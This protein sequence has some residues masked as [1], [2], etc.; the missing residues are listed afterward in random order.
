[1]IVDEITTR[2]ALLHHGQED[3]AAQSPGG[4]EPANS[5]DTDKRVVIVDS[6]PLVRAGQRAFIEQIPGFKVVAEAS[7]GV[8]AIMAVKSHAADLAILELVESGFSMCVTIQRLVTAVPGLYVIVSYDNPAVNGVAS[9]IKA[10]V[11]GF[12]SKAA[13]LQELT[14][15]VQAVSGGAVYLPGPVS[16]NVFDLHRQ[17]DDGSAP[18]GLTKREM[19]ILGFL[20]TGLSNKEIANIANVSVR[21]VETH[22]LSIR[23]K[24]QSSTLS[25]LVRVARIVQSSSPDAWNTATIPEITDEQD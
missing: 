9:L 17:Q 4:G 3:H 20:S 21:T 1:M 13:E 18:Y 14:I 19:E 24:T 6:L 23:R 11:G 16:K 25:D 15:A 2:H 22:R 7:D 12:V 10:G 8:A 5:D